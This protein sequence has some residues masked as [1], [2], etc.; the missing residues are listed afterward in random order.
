MCR[1]FDGLWKTSSRGNV[2]N[3]VYRIS[4]I[5]QLF[6]VIAKASAGM[7]SGRSWKTARTNCSWV[8]FMSPL[9]SRFVRVSANHVH[10]HH[11][12]FQR[13][14]LW[15]SCHR[16]HQTLWQSVRSSSDR[17]HHHHH[18]TLQ[19][20]PSV[21]VVLQDVNLNTQ[22][23]GHFR[24]TVRYYLAD[25]TNFANMRVVVFAV[26]WCLPCCGVCRVV[27]LWCLPCC[28]VVVFAVLW[29][30]PCCG[31]R[32]VVVFAVLWCLT[33]CGVRRV[34]DYRTQMVQIRLQ[35]Q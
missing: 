16:Y 17:R 33:C 30:S 15:S 20:S 26:L 25:S 13:T 27:V 1:I 11:Q 3:I 23:T 5:C 14:G 32:R 10:Q 29:C 8:T 28:G 18:R 7:M 12:T 35:G 9:E 2:C 31:V 21:W 4:K 34:V 6:T 22:S 24:A 19:Q